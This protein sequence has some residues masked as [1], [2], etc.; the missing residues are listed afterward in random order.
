[1]MPI[2]WFCTINKSLPL[3]SGLVDRCITAG[4]FSKHQK[5]EMLIE[6]EWIKAKK[7]YSHLMQDRPPG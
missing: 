5:E 2:P 7:E 6:D 3:Q 4:D 1:M